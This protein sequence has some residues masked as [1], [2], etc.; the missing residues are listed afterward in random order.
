MGSDSP[1]MR[2]QVREMAY[3]ISVRAPRPMAEHA[4]SSQLLLAELSSSGLRPSFD[5]R[6]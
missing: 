6:R 3:E 1:R 4:T 5:S 2:N